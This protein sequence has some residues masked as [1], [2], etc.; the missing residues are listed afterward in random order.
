MLQ[1]TIG[2]E[3]NRKNFSSSSE[4]DGPFSQAGGGWGGKSAPSS[5]EED[6]KNFAAFDPLTPKPC[7]GLCDMLQHTIGVEK[8]RKNFSSSSEKDGPFSQ[9]GGGWGGKS[10]PSSSEEDKK[11][12]AAFDPL[13]PKPCRGL[14]DMLQHTIGVEKNRKNFSSSSEKDGPF[15]QAGGGWGGKSA[16]SSSEEDKKNFAAFDPLTPKPCRGLCDMLQHTIGVEKNR[17]NFSSSSE[18]DGPFSQAGGGWGGKSAPSSSEEDKKN[19]AAFDPLTPKP[20]RGL[21]DMLQH[22]IGV[23]KNRKNFSSSSEKDGPFSQAGGGWGGKSAPSSSEEDKKNFAAF[24][25]LTPKPCRG[26]C[27]MLQH[28][29]GVEKNRK[30]FS[31]SSEKDGPFSQAGGGWGG[32]SA[33]SSSEEDKKNFAAFDPLTPKPCRGL[34]DMLQHTI[35]VEKNR[36]NFSSSSEKDGPFS[37]AGGGWGGKSAPSSSEEDKKNFAAF[38]PLTPKPCR[39]LCDMLQHT[40]GVEKNRKNFSSSSEKDGPFFVVLAVYVLFVVSLD[41]VETNN[42]YC[43]C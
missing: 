35:G 20:C 41:T 17:K 16:P 27:D 6:K 3:K 19:F 38:D 8:N 23:E 14:C 7:R 11:N 24:D 30:N 10:A 26:L 39:G 40:I 18:K 31:S 2:V 28:T 9:A 21:C 43:K 22:T 12:F 32:K 29:I 13:T 33:P 1:H 34:C 36:K 25:P 37:Q 42:Q 15:S 4:K 5:S